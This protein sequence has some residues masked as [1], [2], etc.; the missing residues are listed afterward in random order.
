MTL[1]IPYQRLA[2]TAFP[3][4]LCAITL[5]YFGVHAVNG[6]S[7]LRAWFDI[8]QKIEKLEAEL[9]VS[10]AERGHLNQKVNLLR[11]ESLDPDLL[12]ETARNT[13]GLSHPNDVIILLDE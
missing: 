4:V 5:L 9:E 2:R 3:L 6:D 12:D 1:D 10:R 13:L 8:T 11:A 7:G